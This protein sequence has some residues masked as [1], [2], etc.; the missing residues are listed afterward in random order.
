MSPMFST[1]P[2]QRIK[3][4]YN[5]ATSN[6]SVCLT[7]HHPYKYITVSA[8][9]YDIIDNN[10]VNNYIIVDIVSRH[11]LFHIAGISLKNRYAEVY[12]ASLATMTHF[13]TPA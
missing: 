2:T 7:D 8:I 6:E 10:V 13:G 11:F 3:T 12:S 9:K 1:D 5:I 4:S